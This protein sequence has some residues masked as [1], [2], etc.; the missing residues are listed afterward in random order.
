MATTYNSHIVTDGLV[1]CLDAA[2]PRSYPL[3]GNTWYDLSGNG[4]HGTLTNGPTFSSDNGGSLVFDGTND[5]VSGGNTTS[6]ITTQVTV[7]AWFKAVGTPSNNDEAGAFLFAQSNNYHHGAVL[8]H[9]WLYKK[10]GM[11]TYFNQPGSNWSPNNSALGDTIYHLVGTANS[12]TDICNCYINGSL[13]VSNTSYTTTIYAVSP[14][15]QIGR[16]GYSTYGRYFNGHIYRVEV[17]NRALSAQ[18]IRQNYNA[19][20]GR[21]G[22]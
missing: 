19:T 22:N 11:G 18:E 16:W 20:R 12:A 15:Y 14:L 2:N 6:S 21:Y 13:A 17:Y 8:L 7:S 9:S 4:N 3:S 1:L 5:Y 10:A